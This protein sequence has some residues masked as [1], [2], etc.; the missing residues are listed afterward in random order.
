[1]YNYRL[2]PNEKARYY[3]DMTLHILAVPMIWG[4]WGTAELLKESIQDF[5]NQYPP[6]IIVPDINT[7]YALNAFPMAFSAA[8]PKI[9]VPDINTKYAFNAFPMA[10]SAAAAAAASPSTTSS[11]DF[12]DSSSM[13]FMSS[14]LLQQQQQQQQPA[15]NNH[16][17]NISIDD[18]LLIGDEPWQQDIM[19]DNHVFTP[20]ADKWIAMTEQQPPA[21]NNNNRGSKKLIY[22]L[23]F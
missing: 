15:D 16:N 5:F 1:M 9:I 21:Q 22:I 12:F 2:E 3:L 10:F 4:N 18:L 7:K 13:D 8:A 19:Y 6:K 23:R 20:A 17:N 14:F 11:T